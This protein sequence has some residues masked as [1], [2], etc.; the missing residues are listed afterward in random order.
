MTVTDIV[1][2][3]GQNVSDKLAD[4]RASLASHEAQGLFIT[5]LD[6]V[7]W[8]YNIRGADVL[9]NPGKQNSLKSC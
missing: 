5:A 4:V 7:A 1:L 2:W 3:A 9:Y 8:L 6:E